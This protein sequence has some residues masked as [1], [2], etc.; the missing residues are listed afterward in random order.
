MNANDE[1]QMM[2]EEVVVGYFKVFYKSLT[3]SGKLQRGT[4]RIVRISSRFEYGASK[5]QNRVLITQM[6]L[7]VALSSASDKMICS[8]KF[9]CVFLCASINYV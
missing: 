2:S 3:D 8:G 4:A 1:T 7:S 9:V 6:G 5:I